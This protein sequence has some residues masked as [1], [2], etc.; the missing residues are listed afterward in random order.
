M[1]GEQRKRDSSAGEGLGRHDGDFGSGVQ[2]DAAPAFAGDRAA[3][4]IH[5][6]QYA[7]ALA[8]HL[9]HGRERI[10]RF[11]GLADRDVQRVLLDHGIAIAKLRSRFGMRRNT[12]KLFDQMRADA[13]RDIG[14]SAPENLDP[15]NLEQ[16]ARG[17][18]EPADVRRLETRIESA[19]QRATDRFRLLGDLLAH[20]VV[21][22]G[23][24]EGVMRSRRS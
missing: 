4:D 22:S 20:V 13:S 23:L 24:V 15:A 19:A 18:F 3:D 2:I 21:E 11:A 6:A 16:F 1:N 9:L 14:R 10:E 12:G 7:A 8:L 17:H 5:D